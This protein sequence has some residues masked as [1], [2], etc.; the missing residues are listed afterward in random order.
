MALES[1]K[2]TVKL[3][4]NAATIYA[5]W[6]SSEQHGAFIEGTAEIHPCVGGKFQAWDG[7]ITGVTLSLEEDSRVVQSWRTS[8]FPKDADDSKVVVTFEDA[9]S[10]TTLV[11]LE[12][13][14]IPE[15]MGAELTE[16]WIDHYFTPMKKYFS[17]QAA[18]EKQRSRL[19]AAKDAWT[20]EIEKMAATKAATKKAS[21]KKAAKKAPA[22]KAPA[23]KAAKKAPA[24][25]APAKKAAKKTVKKDAED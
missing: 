17:L 5:A 13:T 8:D 15:G 4:G 20:K 19:Q 11:A 2:L 7:Y 10:G 25:K 9:G 24:K 22:K 21:A 12:H 14:G 16:G 23:K 3:Q 6:M 1:I 18:K